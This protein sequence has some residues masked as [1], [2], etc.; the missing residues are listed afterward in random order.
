MGTAWRKEPFP[1]AFEALRGLAR[2]TWSASVWRTRPVS[3]LLWAP[4]ST[5]CPVLRR[6]PQCL[7]AAVG[8][9]R[10]RSRSPAERP[11]SSALVGKTS[12]N[13][14]RAPLR[15]TARSHLCRG[16]ILMYQRLAER[17][18]FEPSTRVDPVYHPSRPPG[19]VVKG[20]P[21]GILYSAGASTRQVRAG[22]DGPVGT[23]LGLAGPG[24]N[25]PIAA[26]P[27]APVGPSLE[28]CLDADQL[29][30]GHPSAVTGPMPPV[31]PSPTR[32]R[33]NCPN[34]AHLASITSLSPD[35]TL[36]HDIRDGPVSGGPDT[37][38]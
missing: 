2:A 6:P 12:A 10:Q 16:K 17:E 24:C 13:G 20:A 33:P 19:G 38:T 26:F 29:L 34:I 37:M 25:P 31:L 27:P 15:A 5:C 11:V 18:G 28:D 30:R 9:A 7:P 36:H 8:S 21:R 4:T 23:P 22:T 3:I 1:G 14:R 32:T 35:T